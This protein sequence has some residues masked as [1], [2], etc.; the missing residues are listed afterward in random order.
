LPSSK[1][2]GYILPATPPLALLVAQA[3]AAQ[4][5]SVRARRWWSVPARSPPSAPAS[6]A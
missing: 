2:I 6:S 3:F 1:L 4:A 5:A